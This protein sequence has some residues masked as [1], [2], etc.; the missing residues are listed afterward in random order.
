LN[1]LLLQ[2]FRPF[3]VIDRSPRGR[4]NLVQGSL[5]PLVAEFEKQTG[6]RFEV[7]QVKEKFGELRFYIKGGNDAIRQRI[8]AAALESLETCEVCGKPGQRRGTD[9]IRTL[10]DDHAEGRPVFAGWPEA[11]ER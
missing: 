6:R 11:E 3:G 7:V 4:W 2:L 10:C 9:W 5:E 1:A 8:G